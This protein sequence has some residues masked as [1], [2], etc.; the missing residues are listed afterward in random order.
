MSGTAQRYWLRRRSVEI[1]RAWKTL[2]P[3]YVG[4]AIAVA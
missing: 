1:G 3:R 4:G 2:L